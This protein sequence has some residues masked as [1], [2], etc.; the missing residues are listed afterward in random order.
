MCHFL[1]DKDGIILV[2]HVVRFEQLQKEL[3]YL[4][5]RLGTP[6]AITKENRSNGKQAP[7]K[8]MYDQE[9]A[10]LVQDRFQKEIALF[11]YS[12]D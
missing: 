6:L 11:N 10:E 5:N 2:D 9:L 7:H 3:T 1:C 8:E 4:S 12:F